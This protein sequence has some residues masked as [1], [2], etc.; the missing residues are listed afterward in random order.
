[1]DWKTFLTDANSVWTAI[2]LAGGGLLT[3]FVTGMR[4][5]RWS[6]AGLRRALLQANRDLATRN[7][8]IDELQGKLRDH[9][10]TEAIRNDPPTLP[11][12]S[13]QVWLRPIKPEDMRLAETRRRVAV[14]L[15]ANLK[16]GVAKTMIA[17]NLAAY[18][19]TRGDYPSTRT[20]GSKRVL[21]I[22]LDYQGSLTRMVLAAMGASVGA[23]HVNSRADTLFTSSISDADAFQ[24]RVHPSPNL[25]N[26]SFYPAT[27]GL[28]DVETREQFAWLGD[29]AGDDVRFRLLKRL[30]S[31]EF[32]SNF[33]MVIIDT[34]PRLTTGS[35]GA[36]VAATHL[37]VPTAP[38][39]RSIEAAELFL[40]R[41]STMKNGAADCTAPAK[42]CPRLKVIGVIASLTGGASGQIE[43]Q[44]DA[45]VRLKTA[46]EGDADLRDLFGANAVF[47]RSSLPRSQPI[48]MEAELQIPYLAGRAIRRVFNDI[49]AEVEQ[50]M[51]Q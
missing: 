22:D 49:G 16:G 6:I 1:M 46:V 24:F 40:R 7:Q 33:D 12:E 41:I 23:L 14:L 28:D 38:D 43:M 42:L 34:G 2:A 51:S 48:Q 19:S 29:R 37:I 20:L 30:S 26:L 5:G 15:V 47:L 3:A 27:Y 36:I 25:P 35:I 44:E 32:E 18:F 45:M 9:V 8:E 10:P 13:V 17:A 11:P 21:L 4:L 31:P 50:R 39:A